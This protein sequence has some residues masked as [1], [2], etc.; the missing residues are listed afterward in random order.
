MSIET[1]GG[2]GGMFKGDCLIVL[3]R[4]GV[5]DPADASSS[6]FV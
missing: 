3:A 6:N 4:F 1:G 2:G 5:E